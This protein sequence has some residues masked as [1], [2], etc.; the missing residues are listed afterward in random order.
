MSVDAAD[1]GDGMKQQPFRTFFASFEFNVTPVARQGEN[2]LVVKIENDYVSI[3]SLTG[4]SPEEHP[5]RSPVKCKKSISRPK[6]LFLFS[7]TFLPMV[8]Y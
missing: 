6:S 7:L 2:T 5:Y 1:S 8:L 4:A 3:V